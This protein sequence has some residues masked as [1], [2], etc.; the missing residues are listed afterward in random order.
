VTGGVTLLQPGNGDRVAGVTEFAWQPDAG[1][2]LGPGEG[3]EMI[4]WA[5]GEDPLAMGRSPVGAGAHTA[6]R[7]DL[8]GVEGALGLR[9]G[10]SYLWGV[11]LWREPG[12]AVRMLSGGRAFVYERAG[13]AQPF[14]SPVVPPLGGD[15]EK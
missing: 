2:A 5:P 6:V 12:G 1:F 14:D 10:A 13:A 11:R 9:S 4:V 8:T 7:A 15:E 3:Y